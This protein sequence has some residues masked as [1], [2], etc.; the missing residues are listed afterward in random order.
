MP[1]WLFSTFA[2]AHVPPDDST[3][4]TASI[5]ALGMPYLL[6]S[7][8]AIA[9]WLAIYD[10]FCA[11]AVNI[12]ARNPTNNKFFLSNLLIDI[13]SLQFY[14]GELKKK[15]SGAVKIIFFS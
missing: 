10:L 11:L 1:K 9:L 3:A 13:I 2:T 7:T 4:A 12:S 8:E 14:L 6:D 15:Y 5:T